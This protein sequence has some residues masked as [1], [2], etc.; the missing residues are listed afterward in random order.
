MP[1]CV[2]LGQQLYGS[3]DHYWEIALTLRNYLQCPFGLEAGSLLPSSC[4][5]SRARL[6]DWVAGMHPLFREPAEAAAQMK[7]WHN[8]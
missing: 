4:A 6:K 8:L 5:Q 1:Y 3:H 2:F 7:I